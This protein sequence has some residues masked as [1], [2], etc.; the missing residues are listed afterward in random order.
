[1]KTNLNIELQFTEGLDFAGLMKT[2]RLTQ[3]LWEMRT[4]LGDVSI[5]FWGVSSKKGTTQYHV[6]FVKF[7][8]QVLPFP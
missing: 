8:R 1:M 7:P 6:A 3:G 4:S 5:S 2:L